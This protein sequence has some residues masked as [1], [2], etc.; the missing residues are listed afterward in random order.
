MKTFKKLSP[1]ILLIALIPASGFGQVEIT[2][3]KPEAVEHSLFGW[4]SSG[5]YE[6]SV[7]G[8]PQLDVDGVNSA[9]G[10]TIYNYS[11]GEQWNITQQISP[12]DLPAL[13][14]FGISVNMNWETLMIG[15]L[16]DSPSLPFS[17]AV[18]AYEL[19]LDNNEWEQTQRL[20]PSDPKPGSQFGYSLDLFEDGSLSAI[21]AYQADGTASKS[22][23]VYV[24]EKDHETE[25]HP[26]V[27]TQKLIAEDGESHDYFGHTVLVLDY[28]TIAIGAYNASGAKE[29]SGAVYIFE[30]N[31]ANNWVQTQK[32]F[33]PDG[34][35][36]DLFGYTL[37]RDKY[38]PIP[39]KQNSTQK[40]YYGYLLVGAPGTN[41]EDVQ[42]GSVYVYESS[43]DEFVN[44]MKIIEAEAEH[45]A[46]FGISIAMLDYQLF[47]GANRTGF[48]NSGRIYQ[49]KLAYDFENSN[50]YFEPTDFIG[51]QNPVLNNFYGSKISTNN[52]GNVII[53]SPYFQRSNLAN[54]GDV[55]F[56]KYFPVSN[57]EN[58]LVLDYKLDQNYPN[59]FNP[60]TTINYQVKEAGHVKLTVF[61]LLGQEVQVLVNEQQA[62]GAYTASFNA[63]A[64]SS[65]FYFYRLEVNDFTSIKKMMLIK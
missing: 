5:T 31:E 33:D 20:Q 11:N 48:D 51:T 10:V 8:A 64:L 27:Q 42:T 41:Q 35:S 62:N 49:Y 17:G 7:I 25:G 29:R 3:E 53:S 6:W 13:A 59:P 38:I 63:S 28:K 18:Y 34:S 2:A 65:G 30:R 24:F 36:S 60:T 54:S 47:V 1:L 50:Y 39:V 14:N 56:Y 16:N 19:N 57:E 9:G 22:G 32:I 45:N 58:E 44:T 21:G 23:A 4:S 46:H 12:S 52:S 15:A 55:E 43:E 40:N 61:N 37:A 26:W